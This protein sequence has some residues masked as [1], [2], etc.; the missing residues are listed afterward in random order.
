ML[1]HADVPE[2]CGHAQLRL[3][4][5]RPTHLQCPEVGVVLLRSNGRC[6]SMPRAAASPASTEGVYWCCMSMTMRC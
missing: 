1:L 3:A 6:R 5:G 2:Q 4:C